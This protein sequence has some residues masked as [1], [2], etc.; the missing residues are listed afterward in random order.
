LSRS[1]KAASVWLNAAQG[2]EAQSAQNH[3]RQ[4]KNVGFEHAGNAMKTTSNHVY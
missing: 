3:E 2:Q 1:V 4:S